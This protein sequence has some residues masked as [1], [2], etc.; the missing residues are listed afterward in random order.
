M[1]P[2]S[3]F[4]L[5]YCYCFGKMRLILIMVKVFFQSGYCMSIYLMCI[6]KISHLLVNR[7]SGLWN[8]DVALKH[9]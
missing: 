8:V 3:S 2:Q 4:F 9:F 6:T 7:I 1:P 5:F